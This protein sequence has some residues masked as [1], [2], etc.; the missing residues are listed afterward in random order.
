MTQPQG[1]RIPK[2]GDALILADGRR[3]VLR[4]ADGGA[5]GWWF[6]A[7]ARDQHST[8]EGN[9]ELEWDAQA[10]AWRPAG[11]PSRSLA[12]PP[13]VVARTARS[14]QKQMD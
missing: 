14:R 6:K 10:S 7:E 9:L 12:G 11:Q 4:E 1:S 8:L 2:A 3:F 5:R 13:P